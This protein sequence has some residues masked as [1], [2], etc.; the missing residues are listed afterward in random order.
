MKKWAEWDR[1]R[2]Q[3][4]L[5][6]V[7]SLSQGYSKR[8]EKEMGYTEN[9]ENLNIKLFISNKLIKVFVNERMHMLT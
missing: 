4:I 7:R 5:G 6:G 1:E 9:R 3:K 8:K 2:F